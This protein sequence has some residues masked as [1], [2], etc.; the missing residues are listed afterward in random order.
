MKDIRT[1]ILSSVVL[2]L[3][4]MVIGLPERIRAEEVPA[5]S[6]IL[7]EL[8][9]NG[10]E[11]QWEGRAD[12]FLPFLTAKPKAPVLDEIIDVEKPKTGLRSL[13]PGQ[14]TVVAILISDNY[15]LAMVQDVTG[16]GYV[17]KEGLDI[18]AR[19]TITKITDQSVLVLEK[20]KTRSGKEF[21]KTVTMRLN[22]EGDK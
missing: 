7:E 8:A 5:S 1:I 2:A 18:G 11:Y 9:H 3:L 4:V 16:V 14:L 19:G 10:F 21:T 13:E 22:N 17:L 20:M 6:S 12:P 15:R